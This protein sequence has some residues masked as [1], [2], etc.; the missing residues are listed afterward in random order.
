MLNIPNDIMNIINDYKEQLE[1][2][3]KYKKI[4]YEINKINYDIKYYMY[5]NIIISTRD[6]IRYQKF[7][8]IIDDNCLLI[9]YTKSNYYI[10]IYP[11][12]SRLISK[13]FIYH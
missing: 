5:N 2:H 6:N 1:L 8:S 7:R 11:N 10:I 3:D 9:D 12:G 13:T 4:F